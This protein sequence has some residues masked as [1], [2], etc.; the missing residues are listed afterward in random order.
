MASIK[1]QYTNAVSICTVMYL[2]VRVCISL[3]CQKKIQTRCL[4][5]S[6]SLYPIPNLV[7]FSFVVSELNRVAHP[8]SVSFYPNTN[9]AL[10]PTF[11]L[12]F[13]NQIGC[14]PP[15]PHHYCVRNTGEKNVHCILLFTTIGHFCKLY[16]YSAGL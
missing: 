6:V 10:N 15:P 5:I 11:F 8:A 7:T 9:L 14:P 13:H 16:S 1:V 2:H 12:S 4:M 3:C